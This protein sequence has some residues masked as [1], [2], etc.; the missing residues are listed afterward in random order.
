M[1]I[2]YYLVVENIREIE[3]D[4]WQCDYLE[5]PIPGPGQIYEPEFYH[6]QKIAIHRMPL[7]LR[8]DLVTVYAKQLINPNEI[9]K[10]KLSGL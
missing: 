8:Y 6:S 4:E 3:K 9:A 5:Y 10:A 1:N 2:Q 7:P